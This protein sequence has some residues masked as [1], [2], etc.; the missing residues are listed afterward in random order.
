MTQE[1]IEYIHKFIEEELGVKNVGAKALL[2]EL[3]CDWY[4]NY[5]TR[6]QEG[7]DEGYD[8]C[9]AVNGIEGA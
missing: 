8:T 4:A 6:Y 1:R 7:Y 5:K 9:L 3:V 2:N